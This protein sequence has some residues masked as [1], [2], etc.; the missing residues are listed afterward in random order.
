MR[1]YIQPGDTLDLTAPAGGVQSGQ[2]LKIG[3]LVGV[4]ST[5]AA[6]GHKVAVAVEG[7]FSLPKETGTGLSEGAKAYWT[8]SEISGT[9]SGNTLCGHVI[10]AASAG[11]VTVKVRLS[12]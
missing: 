11:A 7:V 12:N 6:E 9:A 2:I 4:A 5:D 3:D 10:E 1:N 8:G